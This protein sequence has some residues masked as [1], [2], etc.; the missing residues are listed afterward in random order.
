MEEKAKTHALYSE[1]VFQALLDCLWQGKGKIS[2]TDPQQILC[3]LMPDPYHL[4]K[5]C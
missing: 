3:C 5:L 1:Y 4:F 2:C